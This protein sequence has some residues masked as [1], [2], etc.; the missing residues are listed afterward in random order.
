M[1]VVHNLGDS[2]EKTGPLRVEGES[3]EA[4]FTDANVGE[5]VRGEGSWDITLPARATGLWRLK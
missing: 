4:L 1:L 5:P 3:A 2:T